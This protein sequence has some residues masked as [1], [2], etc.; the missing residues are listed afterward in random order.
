MSWAEV[1]KG[2]SRGRRERMVV[3]N[4]NIFGYEMVE[5][6]WILGSFLF[7]IE[8]REKGFGRYAGV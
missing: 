5:W 7:W 2:V 8:N 4:L 1:R 3:V 6:V